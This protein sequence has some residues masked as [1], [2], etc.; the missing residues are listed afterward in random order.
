MAD[1]DPD[2]RAASREAAQ[3]RADR[4]R[5]FRA[6]LAT[7]EAEGVPLLDAAGRARLDAHHDALLAA[8]RAAHDVDVSRDEARLSLGMR[9]ASV[10][11]ALALTTAIV[12][13]VNRL[14][15]GLDPWAQVALLVAAPV[16]CLLVTD[17]AARRAG[18]R[19]IAALFALVATGAFL[20]DLVL[21][22]Q[23][24]G[25]VPSPH[26]AGFV[27]ALGVALGYAYG[28][29]LPLLAGIGALA[30]WAMAALA[31]ATGGTMEDAPPVPEHAIAV[32][33]ALAAVG[34]AGAAA[35]PALAAMWRLGAAICLTWPLL[36]LA[37]DGRATGLALSPRL[38]EI[39]AQLALLA[40]GAGATWLGIRR[41]WRETTAAGAVALAGLLLIKSVD[42]WWDWMPRW[43]YFLVLSVLAL[44]V[45]LVLRRLRLRGAR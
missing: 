23:L 17:V 6:E 39:G 25:L 20:A 38:A 22:G 30:W 26:G 9:V 37:A 5:A 7:L 1:R 16:A 24:L 42:W 33:I 18:A 2:A 19:D 43:L 35:R 34:S 3:A 45:L 8:F 13:L 40:G 10:L 32:G 11:G 14:W 15:G 21:L 28:F 4:I 36:V 41:G 31:L 27:A 44:A 29:R 12:L